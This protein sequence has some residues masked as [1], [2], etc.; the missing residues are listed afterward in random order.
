MGGHC[1]RKKHL[2]NSFI[3]STRMQPRGA[4]G[5]RYHSAN[6]SRN[7]NGATTGDGG[8]GASSSAWTT[9]MMSHHQN[10]NRN[11]TSTGG[12]GQSG[13]SGYHRGGYKGS[14]GGGVGRGYQNTSSS[15]AAAAWNG[16]GRARDSNSNNVNNDDNAA[17]NNSAAAAPNT[18]PA[19]SVLSFFSTTHH[20]SFSCYN[21]DT[22]EIIYEDA[23]A[24]GGQETEDVI[25]KV[26]MECRPNLILVGGKVVGNAPLLDCLTTLPAVG[27]D[28]KRRGGHENNNNNEDGDESQATNNPSTSRTIPYQLLKSAAFEPRACKSVI[29]N[30]LRVITLLRR[31]QSSGV[32]QQ[33]H[34]AP[35]PPSSTTHPSSS[36][37]HSLSS[38]IDFD[39]PTLI[40]SLGSL[41]IYLRTTAFRLE[42]GFTVTVNNIR[43]CQPS[44]SYLRL[45]DVTLR[46]LR[47][48]ATDFHPL[49]ANTTKGGRGR[50]YQ[51][52]KEGFSVFSLLDR[53]KNKAG[54]ERLRQWMMQPLRNVNMIRRRHVGMEL[55]LHPECTSP[56]SFVLERL[57]EVGSMDAILLR[58]QRCC[59][60]PND[61]LVL[62]RMLEAA[63]SIVAT[64][65]GE[66]RDKAYRLDSERSSE[67]S[68][69]EGG[70]GGME[71]DDVAD[72]QVTQYPSVAYLDELLQRC[73]VPVTRNLRER[74]ASVIDEEV[75]AE[76]KDH[77]V[78]H[79]GFHE[80]LDRAKETFETLDETLSEVGRQVLAKHEELISLKVV[81]LPQ[82]SD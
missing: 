18:E 4:T 17:P 31:H 73:H 41:L 62:G 55:F 37:F 42:E 35:P 63:Y 23:I 30:K 78:I 65:G 14:N 27:G 46:T 7:T 1:P 64:L 5:N 71:L 75:T 20:L 15:S 24:H 54:R 12:G 58:L 25:Q 70:D 47:I 81:F 52:S 80:E 82:V 57:S 50:R 49:V 3:N 44:E 6:S 39:S 67:R 8:G 29:L 13:A 34:H 38:I 26:L 22:N 69:E 40:R 60:Q 48:F 59:A 77:V 33:L 61:F 45:D 56:V 66:I 79:Y 28:Q 2:F 51:K 53:T 68:S 11:A 74:M 16:R 72:A 32:Q 21:E 36:N 19:L 10:N 76:A 43:R 9:T